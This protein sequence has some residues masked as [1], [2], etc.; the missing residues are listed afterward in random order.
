MNV[1][2]CIPAGKRL[3]RFEGPDGAFMGLVDGRTVEVT[4][5]KDLSDVLLRGCHGT[6]DSLGLDGLKVLPP[7]HK[8]SKMICIGLNYRSHIK[9]MGSCN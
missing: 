6:G 7:V 2:R 3:G 5:A 9:E 8:P 4:D 1:K